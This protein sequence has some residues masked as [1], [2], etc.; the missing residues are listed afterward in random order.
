MAK[1]DLGIAA[2]ESMPTLP[3]RNTRSS[4]SAALIGT[5]AEALARISSLLSENP[6]ML[7]RLQAPSLVSPTIYKF[8]VYLSETMSSEERQRIWA[9]AEPLINSGRREELEEARAYRLAD[10]A[11]REV[12]PLA[13]E[14]SRQHGQDSAC[15]RGLS[16]I[17]DKDT[18]QL[19]I[20]AG[21]ASQ[22]QASKAGVQA[23]ADCAFAA[24][25]SAFMVIRCP[26][27]PSRCATIVSDSATAA[28]SAGVDKKVLVE[29]KLLLIDELCSPR[30]EPQINS[31]PS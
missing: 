28:V 25:R 2:L 10:W 14:S 6:L 5:G 4:S 23:L 3:S 13:I 7:N 17:R 19:A 21:T 22:S 12:L 16:P 29:M 18:A 9:L 27:S 15:L 24:V 8:V 26:E 1:A 31:C 11:I 30:L 20:V